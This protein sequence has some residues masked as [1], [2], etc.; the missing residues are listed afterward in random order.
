[1]GTYWLVFT[2]YGNEQEAAEQDVLTE[3][4]LNDAIAAQE[5]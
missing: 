4:E 5:H 3:Q 1:M 2:E